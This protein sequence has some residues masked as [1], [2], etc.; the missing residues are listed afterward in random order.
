MDIVVSDPIVDVVESSLDVGPSHIGG[1]SIPVC[2]DVGD[3]GVGVV[4]A[5]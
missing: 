2:T 5:G 4:E 3:C 1:H